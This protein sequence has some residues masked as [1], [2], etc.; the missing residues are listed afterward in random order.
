M[1][2]INAEVDCACDYKHIHCWNTGNVILEILTE[3]A[4]QPC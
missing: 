2:G 1:D 4:M 3:K